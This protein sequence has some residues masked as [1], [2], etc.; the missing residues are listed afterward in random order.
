MI[1][2]PIPAGS[3]ARY[4]L[5]VNKPEESEHSMMNIDTT[6]PQLGQ[7][8]YQAPDAIFIESL[9]G[10]VLDVNL[11]ACKLHG[12]SREEL[13]GKHVLELVPPEQRSTVKQDYPH[14][15]DGSMRMYEGYSLHK[16]GQRIPVELTAT[17]V[18]YQDQ[19]ALLIHVRDLSTRKALHE[20]DALNDAIMQILPG[21]VVRMDAN[22]RIIFA[23]DQAIAFLC[24]EHDEEQQ[25]YVFS[26][27]C[28]VL[29]EDTSVGSLLEDWPGY[30]CMDS[31]QR[32]DQTTL[33]FAYGDGLMHWGVFSA[34]PVVDR[35]TRVCLGAVV[36]F[37]DT[38]ALRSTMLALRESE[39][40][41]HL[42]FD[43]A[44]MGM[45]LATPQGR[46]VQINNRFCK[47]LGY[48]W[49]DLIKLSFSQ[50]A[51][52]QDE[53]ICQAFGKKILT[54][55]ATRHSTRKRYVH[56]DGHDVW[57]QLSV[58]VIRDNLGNPQ[59]CLSQ[60]EDLSPQIKA[61]AQRSQLEQ[62]LRQAQ[63]LQAIGTLASGVA[64]DFNNL[65]LAIESYLDMA[66]TQYQ[67]QQDPTTALENIRQAIRQSTGMTRSLLTFARQT[68]G[69]KH[70]V[71]MASLI[72]QSVQTLKP[73][74]PTCVNVVIE[75]NI[76]CPLQLEAD[77]SQIQQL[78]MNLVM[79][80]RDAMPSGGTLTLMLES[81]RCHGRRPLLH[82]WVCDTGIGMDE[83]TRTRLF[84]PF[85]TT[86]SRGQGTG[87][88]L[89]VVHGIVTDHNARIAVMSEPNKGTS[90]KITFPAISLNTLEE[91]QDTTHPAR[92]QKV[93][94]L[95]AD[96]MLQQVLA[97]VLSEH[98][99]Q[100][101]GLPD[102]QSLQTRMEQDPTL[103]YDLL[104]CDEHPNSQP[105]N[106][107][108][109][110]LQQRQ[111]DFKWV[112]MTTQNTPPTHSA[113][114]SQALLLKHP[115]PMRELARHL[116]EI[117]EQE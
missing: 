102:A 111:P 57:C 51:N 63:K 21:G 9:E 98:N 78:L 60:I 91:S 115:M 17:Q 69:S 53:A 108:R 109:Q 25:C 31:L 97:T 87:L 77:T 106:D 6:P 7:M 76:K 23:N 58:T 66:Q 84:D 42:A 41:F 82:L 71:D 36:S 83:Q 4:D 35:Q 33:G 61:E 88:G 86:K 52:P 15:S 72:E 16:S 2:S 11:Q 32:Q 100:I 117:L 99:V 37:I 3:L 47:M 94:L 26:D 48:R 22:R 12:M 39:Y 81:E 64:H 90:F 70:P 8:L 104:V 80:A 95:Q 105:S 62:R 13:I 20:S 44:P 18:S 75:N 68:N 38:T 45:V 49:S 92:L 85:F 65:L 73:L 14:F 27:N 24:L 56:V 55:K 112:L 40:R 74:I 43:H 19:P 116:L 50:I 28:R 89:A 93:M 103:A 29:H 96:S 54:S 67:R 107:L 113:F 110:I 101:D 114:A 1:V 30:R 59:Y 10:Y 46:F 79:N 5:D 34:M